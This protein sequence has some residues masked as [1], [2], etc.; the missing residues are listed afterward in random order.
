VK[1][2]VLL[3]F[4]GT[5]KSI[6]GRRLAVELRFR[7]ADTD[8]LIE[9]AAG[10]RIPEIFSEE[11]EAHFRALE[12][13]VVRRVAAWEGHVISTGGGVPLNPSNMEALGKT[14]IFVTLTAQPEV[15]FRRVKRRAGERPLLKGPNPLG[16]INRLLLEREKYYSRSEIRVDTSEIQ[17]GESVHRIID[18]LNRYP[19]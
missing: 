17:I 19:R 18:Q 13:E 4:M 12:E 3:G 11:G 9:E 8:Y 10:K 16:A 14:G 15:I 1:N 2:I 5:G 7:F 6:I